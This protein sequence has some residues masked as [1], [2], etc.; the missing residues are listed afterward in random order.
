[1]LRGTGGK[2]GAAQLGRWGL[3][4]AAI[5]LGHYRVLETPGA[6]PLSEHSEGAAMTVTNSVVPLTE[7]EIRWQQWG[8]RG[9]ERDRRLSSRMKA[10]VTVLGIG[11]GIAF[12]FA[13][14]G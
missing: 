9:V 1:V 2:S 6:D 14:F 5:S 4:R 13:R 10:V 3:R 8:A 11:F 12:W 7:A